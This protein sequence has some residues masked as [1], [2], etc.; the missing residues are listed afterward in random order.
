MSN[1]N[2]RGATNNTLRSSWRAWSSSAARISI[3]STYYYTRNNIVKSYDRKCSTTRECNLN[4]CKMLTDKA[5]T[6]MI[7][8]FYKNINI[9]TLPLPPSGAE[10]MD[11]N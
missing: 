8:I 3:P 1:T 11:T 10:Q 9:C 5:W 2:Y 7:Y 4:L 6:L